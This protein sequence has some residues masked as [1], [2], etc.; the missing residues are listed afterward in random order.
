MHLSRNSMNLF[1]GA[2]YS[3]RINRTTSRSRG[4]AVAS[5]SSD[6]H[7]LNC[8]TF[9]GERARVIQANTT[10]EM[11]CRPTISAIQAA[12]TLGETLDVGRIHQ[13]KAR[14]AQGTSNHVSAATLSSGL[15][16]S[17]S[18]ITTGNRLSSTTM[19]C[20]QLGCTWSGASPN[21]NQ[22]EKGRGD[23]LERVHLHGHGEPASCARP[24]RGRSDCGPRRPGPCRP[25]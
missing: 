13:S 16:Y 11:A 14:S 25:W 6:I 18:S 20:F 22:P 9:Q 3:L 17:S 8:A 10:T 7:V 15:S 19:A 4:L 2:N 5:F 12:S 23:D 24:T 1:L 21:V